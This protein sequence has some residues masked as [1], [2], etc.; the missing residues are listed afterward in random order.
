VPF[1]LVDRDT[2]EPAWA[3]LAEL[4]A[5]ASGFRAEGTTAGRA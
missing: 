2:P 3:A 4:I 5:A 1:V